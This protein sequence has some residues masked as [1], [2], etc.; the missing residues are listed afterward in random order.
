MSQER[1]LRS[2]V[3]TGWAV[4]ADVSCIRQDH[5]TLPVQRNTH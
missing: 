4:W 3:L 1:R 5:R 2:R